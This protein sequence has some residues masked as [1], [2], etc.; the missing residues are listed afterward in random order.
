MALDK[1]NL[2]NSIKTIIDTLKSYDGSAG[3]T[4]DDAAEK[5]ASDLAQA[6]YDFVT[7]ANVSVQ[8]TDTD[9]NTL[10]GSGA[11]S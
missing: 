9:G 5:F 4:A 11:I 1:D 3:H 6:I 2:K 10:T 7:N 8:V